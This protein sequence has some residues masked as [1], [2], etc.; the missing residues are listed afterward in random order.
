M[1][2]NT[3]QKAQERPETRSIHQAGQRLPK[4]VSLAP[5]QLW[6]AQPTW[7]WGDRGLREESLEGPRP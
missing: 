7:R 1:P 3:S 4:M 2:A 5:G 6:T